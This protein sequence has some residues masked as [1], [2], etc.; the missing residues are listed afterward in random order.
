MLSEVIARLSYEAAQGSGASDLKD[1]ALK[2][3]G[4][5]VYADVG[6]VLV[7]GRDANVQRYDPETEKVQEVR[8]EEWRVLALVK[9][10]KKHPELKALMPA[11]PP[12]ARICP[13]CGGQGH[14][15]N[16]LD[17]GACMGTGWLP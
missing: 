15:L 13:Q 5:P 8:E 11:R 17:C 4:V 10:A 2:T 1:A 9:A 3:G 6:G 7:I 12:T 14:I 16:T